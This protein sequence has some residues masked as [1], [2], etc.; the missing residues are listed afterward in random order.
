[1]IE[2]HRDVG[3]ELALNRR[4]DL[5]R[6]PDQV[7]VVDRAERDAVVVDARDRV[8][9]RED[10]VAA[11]VG[12]DRPVPAH[13]PVQA[14]ELRDQVLAGTQMQ[15]VRVAE[16]DRGAERAELVGVDALDRPFVPTGMKAGVGTSPCAVRRT[17]ARAAPSV[18]VTVKCSHR[19]SIASPKE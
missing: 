12:E 2:A 18:A 8:A 1:M 15:V 14:A 5:G 10:L 3:A 9:Q 11:G 16:Q 6:E 7:A 13:E 4:C 17:P 19:I